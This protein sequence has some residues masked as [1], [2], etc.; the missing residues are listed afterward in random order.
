[1]TI[2]LCP[3]LDP[4]FGCIAAR[5]ER[6]DK[7]FP[8]ELGTFFWQLIH[9]GCLIARAEELLYRGLPFAGLRSVSAAAVVLSPGLFSLA[10]LDSGLD[11]LPYVSLSGVLFG[12]LRRHGATIPELTLW[13]GLFNFAN[14][15]RLATDRSSP[16]AGTL[17]SY[18]ALG[19]DVD[20]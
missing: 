13:H 10:H 17:L 15:C 20:R 19:A 18:R 11:T 2:V 12:T 5:T 3:D 6:T 4:P 14:E 16:P 7:I 1:M 8:G 9:F